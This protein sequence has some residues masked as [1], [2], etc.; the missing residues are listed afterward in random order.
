MW[1]MSEDVQLIA[2]ILGMDEKEVEKIIND[3][4]KNKN[5][6]IYRR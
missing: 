6:G 5:Y 1:R 2:Y 3:R 4:L